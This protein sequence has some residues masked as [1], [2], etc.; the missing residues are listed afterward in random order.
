[1]S[2]TFHQVLPIVNKFQLGEVELC[3]SHSS[4]AREAENHVGV[5]RD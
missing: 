4:G 2:E 3:D 1:M 5:E